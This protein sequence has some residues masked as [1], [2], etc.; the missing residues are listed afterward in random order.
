MIQQGEI[1]MTTLKTRATDFIQTVH[2][3]DVLFGD[4]ARFT[5]RHMTN[6]EFKELIQLLDN[7]VAYTNIKLYIGIRGL[8]EF[9]KQCCTDIES[10]HTQKGVTTIQMKTNKVIF[11]DVNVR[12]VKITKNDD[13]GLQASSGTYGTFDLKKSA[14]VVTTKKH[15]EFIHTTKRSGSVN[16]TI[17]VFIPQSRI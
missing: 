5:K 9:I 16:S 12:K 13:S 3:N 1:T 6:G 10:T 2:R 4:Q 15:A 7:N 14:M 11:G 8:Q 17:H